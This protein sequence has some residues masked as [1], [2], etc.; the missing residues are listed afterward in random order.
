MHYRPLEKL[1]MFFTLSCTCVIYTKGGINECKEAELDEKTE[2][3]L[4]QR[5]IS[6]KGGGG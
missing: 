5:R 6:R 2:E 4:V 3:K 1:Q